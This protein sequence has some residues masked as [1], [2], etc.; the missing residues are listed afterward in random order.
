MILVYSSWHDLDVK[1]VEIVSICT[2]MVFNLFTF[3]LSGGVMSISNFVLCK[4][5]FIYFFIFFLQFN[6]LWSSTGN[7]LLSYLLYM[8]L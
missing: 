3:I 5:C 2:N 6:K 1:N 8:Y 7:T 4:F